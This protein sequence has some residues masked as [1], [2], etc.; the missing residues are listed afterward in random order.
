MWSGAA[1][2][3][4]EAFG[5]DPGKVAVIPNGVPSKKLLTAPD[6]R[7][8]IRSWLGLSEEDPLI[9]YAGALVHEKGLDL[10]IRAMRQVPDA[11]LL[12]VG[13]GPEERVLKDP[14]NN[15]LKGRVHFRAA[16]TDILPFLSAS[17]VAVLPSRGGDS[18]PASLIEAGMLGLPCVAI[19]IGAIPE[20]VVSGTTGVIA[21]V[22]DV[23]GLAEGIRLCLEN[24]VESG[25]AARLIV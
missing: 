16:T 4:T 13:N 17:D 7:N 2:T 1:R 20:I 19:P 21:P 6:R 12:I 24:K 15:R 3:L 10:A 18:M 5:V 25:D 14:V 8:E 23:A 22:E 11:S 9:L